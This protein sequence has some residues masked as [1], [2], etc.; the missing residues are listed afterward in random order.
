[1]KKLKLSDYLTDFFNL[2]F[3]KICALCGLNLYKNEEVLCSK[4]EYN[5]PKTNYFKEKDNPVEK[6]FWGRVPIESACSFYF[7]E[8]GGKYQKLIHTLKY[9][10]GRDVGKYIG[11]LFGLDL[12]TSENYNSIDAIIPVPLH[13]KKERK[14]GYNQSMEIALGLSEAM[15]KP[16]WNDCLK[17]RVYNETQTKKNRFD[18]Y[19]NVENIFELVKVDAVE[20]MHLLIVDDVLTTGATLESAIAELLKG[21]NVKVSVATLAYA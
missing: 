9:K 5:I 16:V 20:N 11:K 4:C 14:R 3:P 18:R 7:F 12:K 10:D 19:K 6:V 8:K 13:P 15:N 21:K 2:F 17:R 1:M